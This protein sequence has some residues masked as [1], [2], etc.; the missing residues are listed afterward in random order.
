MANRFSVEAIIKA[1]D[2][3]TAPVTRMQN[4]VGKFTRAAERQLRR[5]NRRLNAM[6]KGLLRGAGAAAKIGGAAIIGGITLTTVA[7]NKLADSADELAKRTRR[8][9]FPIEEFQEWLFVAEQSGIP[10][11][12]FN[13]SMEAFVK[14]LGEAKA[15]FG[16]LVSGLKKTNPELLKQIIAADSVSE[17]LD[18]YVKAMRSTEDAATRNALANAAFSRSGLAMANMADNTAEALAGLRKEQRENGV[19]TQKQAAAAEAYNDATNSLT[20][21][22]MDL[23]RGPLLDLAPALTKNLRA[24]REWIVANKDM[25]KSGIFEFLDGMRRRLVKLSKQVSEFVESENLIERVKNAFAKVESVLGFLSAHG[26]TIAMV[27]A[28]IVA[29]TTVLNIFIGVMTAVNI[30]MAM[31]PVGLI[32]LG[33]AALIAIIAAAIIWW[34]EITAAIRNSTV[35]FDAMVLAIAAVTGPI[36]WLIGAAVL[37]FKHWEPIKEFFAG[38]GD[39]MVDAFDSAVDKIKPLIDW[40]KNAAGFIV[41]MHS[42]AFGAAADLFGFGDDEG[43]TSSSGPGSQMVSPQERTARSIEERRTTGEVVIRDE[44]GKAS[45]SK[46][47]KGTGAL[48]MT[49][50]GAF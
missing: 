17:A 50:T 21:A 31:N 49:A 42:K 36:G 23:V 7:L 20:N 26:K 46:S 27:V 45:E 41:D 2:R 22:L 8:M 28:G 18:I 14:R 12:K 9:K 43:E 34:D 33:I 6:T 40:L 25:I 16:P 38:V 24:M 47:L 5:V 19:M 11:A 48:L 37:I 32:V 39:A 13:A 29:L 10:Q 30:V 35:A 15:G 4:S 1:K 3:I 44:T